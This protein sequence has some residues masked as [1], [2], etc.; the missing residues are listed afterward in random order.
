MLYGDYRVAYK[1]IQYGMLSDLSGTCAIFRARGQHQIIGGA[2]SQ[3][4][5]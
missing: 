4:Q 5:G 2:P 3:A 1:S